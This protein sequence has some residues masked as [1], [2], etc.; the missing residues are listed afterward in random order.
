MNGIIGYNIRPEMGR[1]TLTVMGDTVVILGR[2]TVGD[3]IWEYGIFPQ[4]H[5]SVFGTNVGMARGNHTPSTLSGEQKGHSDPSIR[6]V[7]ARGSHTPSSCRV[8]ARDCH[9]PSIVCGKGLLYPCN[10]F[11]MAWGSHAPQ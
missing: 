5:I 6:L 2:I 11:G 9:A 10:Y 8:A 4:H 3:N 7:G 1:Y